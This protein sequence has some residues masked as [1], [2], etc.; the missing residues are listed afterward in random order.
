[1]SPRD[2]KLFVAKSDL[3]DFFYRFSLPTWLQPYFCLPAVNSA[4]VGMGDA[5]GGRDIYPMLRVLPGLV[6]FSIFDTGCS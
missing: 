2:S 5:Y 6:T 1:M 4:D 3:S